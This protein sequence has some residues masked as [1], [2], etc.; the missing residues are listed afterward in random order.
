MSYTLVWE[1]ARKRE[2]EEVLHTFYVLFCFLFWDGVLLLLPRLECNGVISAHCN[3]CLVG[4]SNSPAL[5]SWVAGTTGTRH[6][7]QLII[8]FFYETE[9]CSVARLECSS[10]IS[11]HCNLHLLGSSDSST[12]ASRVAGTTGTFHHAR[13]IFFC[14][15]SRDRFSPCWPGWSGS[16]DLMICPPWPPKVLGI[17]AWAT[18][19]GQHSEFLKTYLYTRP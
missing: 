19:P 10:A 4:S 15:F 17:Q 3:L 9:S 16:L 18:V 12:S 5:A 13:L 1:R 11:A 14:I 8:Y 7:A 6:H 2:P